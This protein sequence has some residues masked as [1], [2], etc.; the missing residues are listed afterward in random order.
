VDPATLNEPGKLLTPAEKPMDTRRELYIDNIESQYFDDLST[1]FTPAVANRFNRTLEA[2]Q[3]KDAGR[4]EVD[5]VAA[6]GA[7]TGPTA[8]ETADASAAGSKPASDTDAAENADAATADAEGDGSA[9]VT[10]PQGPGWVIE[11]KLRHYHNNMKN[12]PTAPEYVRQE[13][14]TK[15][16]DDTVELPG[17]AQTQPKKYTYEEL[18]IRFPIIAYGPPSPRNVRLRD[19]SKAVEPDP[20]LG[21]DTF[22]L[23][24]TPTAPEAD[25]GILVQVYE[26][27]VQFCWQPTRASEREEK[28]REESEQA[29]KPAAD[30]DE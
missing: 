29:T 15:F 14:L 25:E 20:L 24:G 26:C 2:K 28:R 13:F 19:P 12:P 5:T 18:G 9:A 23:G 17:T 10:G 7:A 8:E 3:R 30:A 1:W 6:D 4:K 21:A 22:R 16:I 27:Y 11:I